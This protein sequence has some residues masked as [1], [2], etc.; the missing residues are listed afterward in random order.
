[1]H[2]LGNDIELYQWSIDNYEITN[3]QYLFT[4][5]AGLKH[6]LKVEKRRAFEKKYIDKALVCAPQYAPFVK[7]VEVLELALKVGDIKFIEP[8]AYET[9]DVLKVIHAPSNRLKKGTKFLVDAVEKLNKEGFKVDLEICEGISHG[10]LLMKYEACHVSV[11]ALLGG[12]Y[13]TAGIEAM[14]S[15]RP[16]ITFIRDEFIDMMSIKK[17]EMPIISANRDTIYEELKKVA[18]NHYNLEKLSMESRKYVI[19]HHDLK[20][21]TKRLFNIYNSI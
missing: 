4:P 3:M 5:E 10:D 16:I 13:G 17:E 18:L 20:N 2:Y 6:D 15:G 7:D 1:M 12:W 8:R 19:A 14:A 21:L 11:I 9:G